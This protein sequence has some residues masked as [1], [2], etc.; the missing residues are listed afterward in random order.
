MAEFIL[1]DLYSQRQQ[2]VNYVSGWPI[3]EVLNWMRCYGS[4][5]M[6]SPVTGHNI[7][8]FCSPAGLKCPFYFD[9]NLKLTIPTSG[10]YY[11]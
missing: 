11:G 1:I 4:V 6:P 9:E 10:W 3:E 2:T 7:Y 5:K 8:Q